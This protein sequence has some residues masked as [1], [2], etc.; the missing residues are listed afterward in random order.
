MRSLS[1]S[2]FKLA[3]P[4]G[5]YL[6]IL[7]APNWAAK[8]I[9]GVTRADSTAAVAIPL[10]NTEGMTSGTFTIAR[11]DRIIDAVVLYGIDVGAV[12]LQPGFA[13]LPSAAYLARGT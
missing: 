5:I 2:F 13:F 12:H 1:G 11:S 10:R 4:H 3:D 8:G 6:G 7:F 9:A